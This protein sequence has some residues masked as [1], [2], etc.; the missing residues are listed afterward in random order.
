M[1]SPFASRVLP[2]LQLIDKWW[3]LHLPTWVPVF[4]IGLVYVAFRRLQR[5]RVHAQSQ[6]LWCSCGYELLQSQERCPEC[7]TVV[8]DSRFARDD[9]A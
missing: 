8:I 4:T 7:G 1:S 5:A 6:A 2:R 3:V 9:S